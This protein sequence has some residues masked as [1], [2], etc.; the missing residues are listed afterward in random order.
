MGEGP[1]GGVRVVSCAPDDPIA[2]GTDFAH[3]AFWRGEDSSMNAAVSWV[4]RILDGRDDGA[5]TMGHEG[6]ERVRRRVLDLMKR[7]EDAE[8]CM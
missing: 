7:V 8:D 3:P 1:D 6:L 2:D 5:G 4:E